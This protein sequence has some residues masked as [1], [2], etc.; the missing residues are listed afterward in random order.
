M[1]L[2]L[3]LTW[4]IKKIINEKQ[5]SSEVFLRKDDLENRCLESDNILRWWI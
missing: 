4:K 3:L 5:D 2:S 1:Q